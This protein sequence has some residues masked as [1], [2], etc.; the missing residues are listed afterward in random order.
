MSRLW[1]WEQAITKS[2]LE[3][4]TRL[5]L[6]TLATDMDKHGQSCFPSVPEISDAS[7]L[8]E[9]TISKHIKIAQKSGWL[10]V[11]TRRK[12]GQKWDHNYYEATWPEGGAPDAGVQET[13][14]GGAPD[15][16]YQSREIKKTISKDIS[17]KKR[18]R[19]IPDGWIP[20]PP[21]PDSKTFTRLANFTKDETDD[22]L[23]RFKN[24]HIGKQTRSADFNA[25]WRTWIANA[26]KWGDDK[27]KRTVPEIGEARRNASLDALAEYEAERLA[28][29]A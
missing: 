27:P 15:A 10:M 26:Q 24:Y 23:E 2:G 19:T 18:L 7:G 8:G 4:T 28:A 9:R 29:Q 3:S 5:L 12:A 11:S 13:T 14:Q 20:D 16:H 17:K 1:T 25:N 21:S 6:F 22:Q